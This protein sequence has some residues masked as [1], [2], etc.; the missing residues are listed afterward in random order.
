[1]SI[2]H[3]AAARRGICC[4]SLGLWNP[5]CN[6][7]ELTWGCGGAEAVLLVWVKIQALLKYIYFL[8]SVTINCEE[9]KTALNTESILTEKQHCFTLAVTAPVNYGKPPQVSS[10]FLRNLQR[11]TRLLFGLVGLYYTPT[12][13]LKVWAI[14]PTFLNPHATNGCSSP[15]PSGIWAVN[16]SFR[17]KPTAG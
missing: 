2:C 5:P 1:M 10:S 15:N 12:T 16:L 6:S 4:T 17:S 13:H 14:K 8:K 3:K 9:N 7:S 11:L